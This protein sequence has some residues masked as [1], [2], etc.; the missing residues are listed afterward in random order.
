MNLSGVGIWSHQLRYGVK[1]QSADAAAE[2]D[3]LGYTAL[4]I[5]DVGQTPVLDSVDHLLSATN[6]IVVA[7]GILNLWMN[8]PADVAASYASLA[9]AHGDRFLMGIGV[10]HAPLIDSTEPGRYR[11]PLAATAAFLDALDDEQPPV[12]V[13]ARVLAALGPK[14][15]QLAADRSR[16]AHPYLVSPEHTRGARALLGDGPLLLPEQTAILTEDASE[17]RAIGM[18]W[19]KRYLAMP[20][21]ANS[22]LRLG[23]SPDDV[24]AV[25]DRLFDAMIVWGDESAVV[26]RVNEHL[27]AGA[28]H[29][30]VQVL[31]SDL[32]EYP[33]EQWRRIAAALR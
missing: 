31:T 24:D 4:W 1:A 6:D 10:S 33:R 14:M 16:G 15:L 20:N 19:L 23:F 3:E 25:S 9:T 11:K 7:T 18:G 26:G 30:C 29:V 12:P 5:P 21:Y 17:A 28:D 13:G 2:L 32:N 8:E 22:M 27:S